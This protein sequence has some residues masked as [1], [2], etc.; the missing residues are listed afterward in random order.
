VRDGLGLLAARRKLDRLAAALDMLRCEEEDAHEDAKAP[1]EIVRQWGE[2]RNRLLVG[3][4]V[5]H[6][7]LAR[8]ESRGAHCRSDH[9]LPNPA[10]TRRTLTLSELAG[11]AGPLSGDAACCIL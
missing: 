6:A 10:F 8:Q 1:P 5:V 2:A 4:L 11:T 7:A 9:P 3:R